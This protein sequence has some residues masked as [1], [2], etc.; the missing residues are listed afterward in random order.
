LVSYFAV[1]DKLA[2]QL[3]DERYGTAEPEQ[4]QPQE[5]QDQLANS[6]L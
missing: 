6:A 1:G 4:S 5:V 3:A 2:L